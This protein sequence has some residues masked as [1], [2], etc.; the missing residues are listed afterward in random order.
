MGQS[1]SQATEPS[2]KR[3]SFRRELGR[4]RGTGLRTPK[5]GVLKDSEGPMVQSIPYKRGVEVYLY[6][7]V[8]R[9]QG[10]ILTKAKVNYGQSK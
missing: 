1:Q 2:K 6:P 5:E 3:V 7:V 4:R 8:H 10:L 9:F